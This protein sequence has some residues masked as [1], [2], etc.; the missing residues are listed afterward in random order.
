MR[1]EQPMRC[2]PG[3]LA[4][5]VSAELRCNVGIIVRIIAPHDGAGAIRFRHHGHVWLVAA[6]RPMT[7]HMH[8][9]VYRRKTGPVPDNRLQPIRG[10]PLG[11]LV[12]KPAESDFGARKKAERR[13][14]IATIEG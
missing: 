13:R 5:V 6:P 2:K 7:W 14:S 10:L 1:K 12:A 4:V 9:K 11:Y 3:D 8:G